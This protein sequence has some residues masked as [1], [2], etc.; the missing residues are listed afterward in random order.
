MHN[1]STGRYLTIISKHFFNVLQIQIEVDSALVLRPAVEGHEN[2][3]LN[4]TEPVLCHSDVSC[5]FCL[6]AFHCFQ[7]SHPS[8]PR[9]MAPF[10]SYLQTFWS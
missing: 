7:S 1:M 8:L 6:L 5:R 3:F 10:C 4:N 9:I 2:W